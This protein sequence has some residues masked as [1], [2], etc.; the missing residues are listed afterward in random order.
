MQRIGLKR[1]Y[2][3]ATFRSLEITTV[4]GSTYRYLQMAGVYMIICNLRLGDSQVNL[5]TIIH[6]ATQINAMNIATGGLD[7]TELVTHREQAW[8]A[9]QQWGGL[10]KFE[11]CPMFTHFYRVSDGEEVSE[12]EAME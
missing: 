12:A 6:G 9:F 8:L 10:A 1:N 2:T 7:E 3:S 4:G 5:G 11:G